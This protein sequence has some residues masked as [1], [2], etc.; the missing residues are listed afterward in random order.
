MRCCDS[1]ETDEVAG[2][3]LH[4]PHWHNTNIQAI[5]KCCVLNV[6]NQILIQ[7]IVT[8]SGYGL[9]SVIRNDTNGIQNTKTNLLE[10]AMCL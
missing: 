8:P 2:W 3:H 6:I 9:Y 4:I 5:S 7:W 1:V 10:I